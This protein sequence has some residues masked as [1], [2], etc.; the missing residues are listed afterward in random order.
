[1]LRGRVLT[2]L[3]RQTATA[4]SSWWVNLRQMASLFFTDEVAEVRVACAGIETL[5]DEEG[6]FRLLVP[7]PQGNRPSTM[8]V[9]LPDTGETGRQWYHPTIW[10]YLTGRMRG[11]R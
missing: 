4:E 8:E 9:S 6:Y 2:A 5:T 7:L 10:G 11:V 1:M 3:R